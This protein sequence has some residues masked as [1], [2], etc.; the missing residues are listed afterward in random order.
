MVL[1][2]LIGRL[3]GLRA[4]SRDTRQLALEFHGPPRTGA[5]F[6][7][8]LQGFGLRGVRAMTLTRN[9]SVMVSLTDGTLRVHRAFLA[10]PEPV[11]RAIVRFLMA[12]RRAE[13]LAARRV[14]TG[15]PIGDEERRAP[16]APERTHPD[17]EKLAASLGEWHARYNRERF[18]GTLRRVTVRVSRRMR[19]RLGHYAP[20]Q[21]GRPAEIAISRRHVRR[22]GVAEAL[23]TLL[24]EMVHQWQDEQGHPLGHD[25]RFRE[26]SRDVGIVGRAKR[27]VD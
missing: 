5:E 11:H 19:A 22:H 1:R 7:V 12:S 17:D 13:R 3:R 24:H 6:L 4:A 23:E 18:G 15:Y 16:R 21:Q 9:R 26:K 27:V 10:A 25:R 2:A 20:A 8:R 14:L